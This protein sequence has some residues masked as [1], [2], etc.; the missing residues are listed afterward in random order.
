VFV[1]LFRFAMAGA[2]ALSLCPQSHAQDWPQRP[3]KIMVI[4]AP[5][6]LPDLMA[7]L[8]A[9][10]LTESLGQPVV[11]ENRAGARAATWRRLRSPRPRPTA[12]RFC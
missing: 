10:H 2:L 12:I 6:G 11:V 3:L 1:Q 9:R 4:A 7:R 5:G 8:V